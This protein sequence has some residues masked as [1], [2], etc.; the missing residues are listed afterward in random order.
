MYIIHIIC[1]YCKISAI[2]V[3]CRLVSGSQ[4]VCHGWK[5]LGSIALTNAAYRAREVN[6]RRKQEVKVVHVEDLNIYK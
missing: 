4:E 6:R 3:V 5:R 1:K 2:Y